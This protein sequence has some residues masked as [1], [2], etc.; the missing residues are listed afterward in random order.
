MEVTICNF[1]VNKI[2]REW[3]SSEKKV[4]EKSKMFNKIITNISKNKIKYKNSKKMKKK[5]SYLLKKKE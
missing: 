4:T 5:K 2:Q 1:Y 3:L